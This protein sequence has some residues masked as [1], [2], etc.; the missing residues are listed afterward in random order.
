MAVKFQDPLDEQSEIEVAKYTFLQL[1]KEQ[2][3]GSINDL[4]ISHY[5]G[6]YIERL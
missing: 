3:C 5:I 6:A 1:F 2:I 4:F